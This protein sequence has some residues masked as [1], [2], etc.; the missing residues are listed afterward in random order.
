MLMSG[1][2]GEGV[3]EVMLS[4]WRMAEAARARA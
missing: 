2:T 4:V 3:R 1:A